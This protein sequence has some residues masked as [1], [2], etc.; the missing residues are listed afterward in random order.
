MAGHLPYLED[1][2][3]FDFDMQELFLIEDRT[4]FWKILSEYSDTVANFSEDFKKLIDGMTHPNP[5]KRMDIWGIK[6]SNWY[7]GQTYS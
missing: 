4:E 2:V 1:E 7:N 6:R 5:K 3:I